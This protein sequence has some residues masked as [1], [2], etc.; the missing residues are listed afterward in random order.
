[1]FL[2]K[3]LLWE[4]LQFLRSKRIVLMAWGKNKASIIK[5]TIQGEISSEVPATFLQNHNNTTFVL[6]RSCSFRIDKI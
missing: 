6:D 2:K 1:M 4:F 5:R 3:Q